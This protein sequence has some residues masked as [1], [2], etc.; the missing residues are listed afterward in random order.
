M[1]GASHRP[2]TFTTVFRHAEHVIARMTDEC[3]RWSERHRT[4][5]RTSAR[6]GR[7]EMRL[8]CDAPCQRTRIGVP[9]DV[10]IPRNGVVSVIIMVRP[11]LGL[12]LTR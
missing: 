4:A 8:V 9:P 10:R 6:T 5:R 7:S 2:P 1:E 3:G 11:P 12:V